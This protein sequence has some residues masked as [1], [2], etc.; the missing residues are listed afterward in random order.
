MLTDGQYGGR[1]ETVAELIFPP[2]L[3][4]SDNLASVV[5]KQNR[6]SLSPF[7]PS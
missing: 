4:D 7:L 3:L 2:T 6:A 5:A 1:G